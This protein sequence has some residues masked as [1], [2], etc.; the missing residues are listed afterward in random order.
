MNEWLLELTVGGAVHRYA[1]REVTV[2]DAAGRSYLYRAGLVD[3][4][5]AF[6]G[7]VEEQAVEVFDRSV[8]WAQLVA[9]GG[10]IDGL[11]ATLR[12]WTRGDVLE[13]AQVVLDGFVE[14]PEYGFPRAAHRLVLTVRESRGR[15]YPDPLASVGLQT[16]EYT[17]GSVLFDEAI[18]G[19]VYPTVFGYPGTNETVT[20][21][22]GSEGAIPAT[23]ALL[24]YYTGTTGPGNSHLMVSIGKTDCGEQGGQARI[25]DADTLNTVSGIDVIA[26]ELSDV[27]I[28]ADLA[29]RTYSMVEFDTASPGPPPDPNPFAG[30]RYFM[31][32]LQSEGGGTLRPDR[33]GPIRSLTDVAIW[34]LRN[35]GRRVD[36]RAQEAERDRLD[37]FAVDGFV[38]ERID[39]LAWFESQMAALFPVVRARTSRGIYWRFVDW[40]ARST[41]ALLHLR[42]DT[43][44]V[45]RVTSLRT[46]REQLANLFTI[47]YAKNLVT[48]NYFASRS[49]SGQ[50]G[51]YPPG[52][53]VGGFLTN[54]TV[55]GSRICE[56]SQ[57]QFGVIEAD[58]IETSF[59][60]SDAV[61]S[62]ILHHIARRDA[63]PRRFVSYTVPASDALALTTGDVVTIA[64]E[65]VGLD[66]EVALVDRVEIGTGRLYRLDLEIL[67]PVLRTTV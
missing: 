5:M 29:G 1:T 9:R 31:G 25:F 49:L 23:P 21:I 64:D 18:S 17:P 6:D 45:R 2:T 14:E 4:S 15:L 27:Q 34:A 43:G 33:A 35:S 55:L 63:F 57:S 67:D 19:A 65:E 48:G 28:A 38:S 32:W 30:H 7:L 22:I 12:H 16:F 51:Q 52:Q 54:E 47:R 53:I 41:D 20:S 44:E 58:P 50:A 42:T 3:F 10:G 59:V 61:A 36:L 11:P 24:V 66:G 39:T 46:D 8:N 62:L 40:W 56:A 37:R 26:S 60:W 13:R